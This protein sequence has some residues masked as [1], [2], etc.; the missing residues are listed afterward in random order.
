MRKVF[1]SLGIALFLYACQNNKE[2]V[3]ADVCST[4]NVTYTATI[5]PIINS[6]GC[7]NCHNSTLLRG[8][9]SL[10]T[11]E[12]VKAK[13]SQV[14]AGNAVLYGAVA[15]LDGFSPMPKGLSQ[16]SDCNIAKIKAWIDNN[17]PQ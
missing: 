14:R 17:T 10:E 9:F 3:L 8:G 6:G 15:H 11:Y 12:Q 5:A 13:A 2:E 7:L 16:L 4:S 1:L